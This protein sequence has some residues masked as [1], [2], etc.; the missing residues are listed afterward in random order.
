MTTD[1]LGAAPPLT[2]SARVIQAL[3]W[4]MIWLMLAYLLNNMLIFWF[5]WPGIAEMI[6]F[7]AINGSEPNAGLAALQ[8]G[9]YG[10]AL[11]G[12]VY[13][14]FIR[15]ASLREDAKRVSDANAYFIRACFWA[16][17]F[18]GVGD[19]IIS[20]MRIEELLDPVFGE[21]LAGALRFPEGRAMVL[22]GPLIV[23]SFILAAFT[24]TLGFHWLA[25]LVVIAEL[26]IV[27]GRFIFSYEQAFMADLVRFWYSALFLFASAYTLLEDGHVR[28]DVFYAGF[29]DKTKGYVNAIGAVL[30]GMLLCWTVLL[31]GTWGK[32]NVINSP[33]LAV[34]VTQSSFGAY[35]KYLMAGFLAIF[36]ASMMV[37]FVSALFEGAADIRDEPGKREKPAEMAH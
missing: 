4:A 25:L 11:L 30:L 29:E 19:A 31:M 10:A 20:F 8:L 32:A 14:A 34:E 6:G 13:L 7:G 21:S 5:G 12:A 9:L 28:V 23:I 35:L 22:H 16:A 17:L 1:A 27:V 3:G 18:I 15:T 33:I 37:Q 2:I 26:L 36:A 24:R